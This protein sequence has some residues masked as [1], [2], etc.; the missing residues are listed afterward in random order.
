MFRGRFI[1]LALL[2]LSI[3]LLPAIHSDLHAQ[4]SDDKLHVILGGD[5]ADPTI[6]RDGNDFYMTHSSYRTYPG[7]KIWH[8]TNLVEWTPI[9]NALGRDVGTVWAP[10]LIHH[11]GLFYLYFPSSGKNFVVTAENPR[12]P[13]SDPIEL[14]VPGIDPGHIATPEGERFLYLHNGKVV[15]LS[16]D[17]LKVMGGPQQKHFGWQYPDDWE[18]ECFCL[19]SPKLTYRNGYYYMTAAQGGTA[20]PATSHMV[21]SARSR[22]PLGP[23]ENSPHNPVVHTW[24]R[25]ETY[26]C[27]GHGTIIDDADGNWYV[28]YHGYKKDALPHGRHTLLES[29]QWTDDGWFV[30]KRDPKVEPEIIDHTNGTLAD[31]SFDS[32]EL[33]LQ[34]QMTGAHVLNAHHVGEGQ[35]VFQNP[36]ERMRT[37]QVIPP[38]KNYDVRIEIGDQDPD[39]ELG[40]SI[41][42]SEARLAGVAVQNNRVIMR[43]NDSRRSFR[44]VRGEKI[45]FLRVTL[46]NMTANLYVSED[47]E[48]WTKCSRTFELSGYDHNVLGSFSYLRPA[49]YAEGTGKAAVHSFEYS[50]LSE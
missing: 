15:P 32:H 28:V 1:I 11:D 27:K 6:V 37:L 22:S 24:S 49:I 3:S 5:H 17:G 9:A 45:R 50:P 8:S 23:W 30:L 13:W 36:D 18:V 48:D 35:F 16:K 10:E 42:Y 26:W 19:E 47:G 38:E 4:P 2:L 29:I 40:L 39:V 7:L 14:D 46:S 21:T 20:G 25:N 33:G 44:G 34:W 12:G 43:L 41:W 31:D